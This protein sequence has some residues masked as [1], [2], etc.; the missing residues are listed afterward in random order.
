MTLV[1]ST[2]DWS[3][4]TGNLSWLP[5]RTVYLCRHGSHAYGTALP[6]S[7]EDFRGIAIPPASYYFGAFD[8]FEQAECK[9]PDL[10][11]FDFRKFVS[12]A[13]QCNPNVIEILFVE[14]SDVLVR[15]TWAES[16]WSMRTLFLTKRV[17]HT[18]SGYAASQLG[19]IR[20]HYRWLKN[21]PTRQ[22]ARADF[23]LPEQ[24]TIPKEHLAAAEAAIRLQLDSWSADYLDDLEPGQR[25]AIKNR[26]ASHLAEM[27]VSMHEDLW[28]GAARVIGLDDNLIELMKREK[29]YASAKKE[30]R[31][32][33]TWKAERN[34]QRAA[35]EAR[36]GYDT[37]HAMHL[38]RLL[39]MCREILAEEKVLV[40]RPDA[41]EL[42][43]IRAGAWEYERLVEWA[44]REDRELQ[45]V[46]A[47]SALPKVPDIAKIDKLIQEITMNA[48]WRLPT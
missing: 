46:A 8:R 1:H 38:V 4:Y 12:L 33:E 37:K 31:A 23:G 10:T 39:R 3:R 14:D 6:T 7:D 17:R 20:R 47:R 32:Y 43:A 36:W 34:P 21:P 27:G 42:L 15:S 9:S 16:L 29:Q 28:P 40:R 22:P 44:E 11:V 13:S 18:F 24:T 19:R 30:W 2:F 41:E 25:T 45:E 35:L 26:M 5:G 48:L